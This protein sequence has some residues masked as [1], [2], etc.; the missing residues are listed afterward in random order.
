MIIKQL[1][2]H[3]TSTDSDLRQVISDVKK[4]LQNVEE[5]VT[6]DD[7]INHVAERMEVAVGEA[8]LKQHAILQPAI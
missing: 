4:G 5:L 6:Y 7:I 2:H 8:L 1:Q 3:T